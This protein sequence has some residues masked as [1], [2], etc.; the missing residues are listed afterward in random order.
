MK[1]RTS[2]LIKRN[3]K[4]MMKKKNLIFKINKIQITKF[5]K[6]LLVQLKKLVV[7]MIIQMNRRPRVFLSNQIIIMV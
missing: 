7:Q 4:K 5:L 2:R 3:K 1:R 6:K